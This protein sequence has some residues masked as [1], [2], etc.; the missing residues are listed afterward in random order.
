LDH[1]VY[2]V[3]H[4]LSAPLKSILGLVNIS[5]LTE[6]NR[7]NKVY[8]S[9]IESSVLRLESLIKEILDYSRNK[10]QELRVEQIRLRTLC[11]EILDNLAFLDGY[12]NICI[13]TEKIEVDEVYNDKSRLKLIL[14]N[15]LSNA[16]LFQ[17]KTPGHQPF[18]KISTRRENEFVFIS[19]EDN[20]EGI[21][22]G[23]QAKIFNMFFRGTVN[24]KGSGLGLYI[25]RE[26]AERISG[27][28][29]V[30]SEY[31]KGS[32]FTLALKNVQASPVSSAYTKGTLHS[33]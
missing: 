8:F 13:L 21:K 2:S 4:D 10:R 11:E 17:K 24:S 30:Q 19:I 5:R 22:P 27:K 25:A 28:I 20:G 26:A 23:M 33:N 3:S 16:I 7:E 6:D 15:L 18:V 14:N 31:G 32:I 1:L 29:L 12:Q 9:K